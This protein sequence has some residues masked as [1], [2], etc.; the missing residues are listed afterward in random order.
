MIQASRFLGQRF[1]RAAALALLFLAPANLYAEP[2]IL[3][4][5]TGDTEV[6]PVSTSARGEGQIRVLPDRTVSGSI[7][8]SGFVPT[9]AHIHEAPAGK[10]GPPIVTL[11]PSGKDRFAVHPD[12]RLT[13]AQYAS[14]LA[15]NLYLNVH[16]TQYPH[17]QVRA[18][19]LRV[20][21]AGTAMRPA[22]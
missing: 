2:P 8:L 12:A 1:A 10:N 16:S 21:T 6:P 5:L 22:K 11:I 3:I 9:M 17:G 14:Y 20:D 19:L 13:D 18:Q 15:G 4:S 7:K